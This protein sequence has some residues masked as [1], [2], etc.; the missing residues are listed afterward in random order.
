MTVLKKYISDWLFV[1]AC[2]MIVAGVYILW[3][4]GVTLLVC[5]FLML[6]ILVIYALAKRDI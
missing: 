1:L 4:T 3:G 2:M 6:G 5:G